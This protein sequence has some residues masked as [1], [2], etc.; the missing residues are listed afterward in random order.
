MGRELNSG[1]SKLMELIIEGGAGEMGPAFAKLMDLAMLLERENFLGA[2]PYERTKERIGYANGTKPKSLDT[3][4]GTLQINVPK[5]RGTS[6]PFYPASLERGRRS[7]RAVQLC[8]AQ[9]YIQGVSTRDVEKVLAEFGLENLSSTQV[10][11]ATKMLDEE[12]HAWRERPLAECP[13]LYL[14][15]R[16]E[17]VRVAGVVRSVAVLSAMGV[18]P[19]G[20]RTILGVSVALSEA[21]IHWRSFLDSL[22]K[23]G[24]RGVTCITSDSH[25]GLES[26]RQAVFGGVLWQRCQFHFAQNALHHAPSIGIRKQLGGQLREV[27]NAENLRSAK[28]RLKELVESYRDKAPKLATWLESDAPET[29]TVMELPKAHWRKMRTSNPIERCIQQEIKRRTRKIRLFPNEDALL[30]LVTAVL[31]EIDDAW[32]TS[33][34]AYIDWNKTSDED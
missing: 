30:R 27:W 7:T 24:L 5:T 23:R 16:Y 12:L 2:G 17:K 33:S 19:D 9:M 8:M 11:R 4:A 21:E 10:S 1:I 13:Y 26:A 18:R 25:A 34:K 14:D 22:V 32:S 20:R 15:A 29:L 6:E 31:V 3:Q 28:Q